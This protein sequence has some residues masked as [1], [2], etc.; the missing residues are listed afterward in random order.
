[1]LHDQ[2]TSN[3][4]SHLTQGPKPTFTSRYADPN[5]PASSG[6]LLA[7]VTGGHFS[8]EKLQSLKSARPGLGRTRSSYNRDPHASLDYS[9]SQGESRSNPPAP[10]APHG[11]PLGMDII[12]GWRDARNSRSSR[13][14]RSYESSA[15]EAQGGEVD[16]RACGDRGQ[17]NGPLAPIMKLREQKILY[18]AIV[19][20]PSGSEM[21]H[22]REA[23]GQ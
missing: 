18:L 8:A 19:N 13:Q 16:R 10:H 5:H 20:M 14:R 15:Y 2:A 11:R 4:D 1:M 22:A 3:P 12:E 7:L 6:D 9:D 21:A 17:N 23:L